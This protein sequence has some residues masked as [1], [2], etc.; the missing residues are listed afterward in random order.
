[1]RALFLQ[2]MFNALAG[3]PRVTP[4]HGKGCIYWS[5]RRRVRVSPLDL[6]TARS[7]ALILANPISGRVRIVSHPL[8]ARM[9]LLGRPKQLDFKWF[10]N[11]TDSEKLK[12]YAK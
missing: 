4:A 8:V 10:V 6:P 1:M 12:T 9:Q 2:S 11:N 3:A 7:R 5:L